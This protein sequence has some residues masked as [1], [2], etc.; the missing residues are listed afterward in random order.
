MDELYTYLGYILIAILLYLI[1][2]TIFNKKSMSKEG[3][4]GLFKETSETKKQEE[5]ESVSAIEENIKNIQ[6]ATSKTIEQMNL[7]KHRKNWEELIV[8]MEDRINSASLQSVATLASMIKA[9][10][11]NEK[12]ITIV[13]RF[14]ELNKYKETLKENMKYLD[15]LK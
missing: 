7:V 11:E 3:F 13:G 1:M 12:L 5:L 8:A 15:G 2:K 9:D 6:D 4:T 14:N 10:P